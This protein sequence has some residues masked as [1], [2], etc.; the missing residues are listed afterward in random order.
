QFH[1]T[2][3]K[4]V[5][6]GVVAVP[7]TATSTAAQVAA[8]IATAVNSNTTLV[9]VGAGATQNI[10]NG[11]QT[12]TGNRVDLFGVTNLTSSQ[13]LV[14]TLAVS[15]GTQTLTEGTGGSTTVT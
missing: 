6:N 12:V 9:G 11:V 8:A 1:Q 2:G 3:G 7:F 14:G 5:P 15:L 4:P 10:I 13:A